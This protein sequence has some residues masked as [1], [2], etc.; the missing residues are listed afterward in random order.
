MPDLTIHTTYTCGTNLT[1]MKQVPGSRPGTMH[2]VRWCFQPWPHTTQYDWECSCD[3]F[4]FGK[5]VHCKHIRSVKKERCGW[6]GVLD[7]VG[8]MPRSP[9]GEPCC[10]ECGGRVEA[11]QVGV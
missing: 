7:I 10:P 1:W 2:T 11:M 4:K 5:G 3:A 8:E 6:N 9:N